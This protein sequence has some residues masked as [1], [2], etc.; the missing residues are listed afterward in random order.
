MD[1]KEQLRSMLAAG[2]SVRRIRE[3]THIHPKTI[4]KL[5]R[6]WLAI[7]SDPPV[8]TGAFPPADTPIP[9]AEPVLATQSDSQVSTEVSVDPLRAP[10]QSG[11][12]MGLVDVIAALLE[13]ASDASARWVWQKLVENH[14]YAGSERS[15]SRYLQ[16]LHRTSPTFFLRLSTLPGQEAQVDY[17]VGPMVFYGGKPRR[18]WFFKMT[19]SHSRHSYEELVFRQDLETF[20]RCHEN[21]F[22]AFG[23][24]PA[25]V[26]IDNLKSG[27]LQAHLYEP[28]LN[29]GYQAFATHAGFVINPCDA[30]QPQ[31]KGKVERD[32]SFTRH[33]AFPGVQVLSS[34]ED[35]NRLLEE[36]NRRW[37]RTRIHGTTRRQV[38]EHF[39]SEEKPALKALPEHPFSM[40]RQGLR[41]VD[42]HGHIQVE[43]VFYSVPAKHLRQQVVARWDSR[44]VKILVADTVVAEHRRE[45]GKSRVVT[46]PGHLPQGMPQNASSFVQYYLRRS[47][48]IGPSC[49]A[50]VQHLLT[51]LNAGNPLAVKRVRGIV[52][53]LSRR[54]GAHILEQACQKAGAFRNPTWSTL[55]TICQKL[56]E[57][58]EA[59][60]DPDGHGH[61]TDLQQ[62][63]RLI[64]DPGDYADVVRDR[65]QEVTR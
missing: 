37:A 56:S 38:W 49:N 29:A 63:H 3:A 45:H 35:G 16:K 23:G 47:Q 9:F 8:S 6:H 2:W 28:R 39:Q 48:E 46:Q 52:V 19:L 14:D 17:A 55:Q 64:R 32:V 13:I 10:T 11:Q 58:I 54:F 57:E 27:V 5:R 43:G 33:N 26:K 15:V 60:P 62:E 42:V 50:L 36:W 65:V 18:S 30:Y 25:E 24:V 4:A 7:Q 1:K 40:L 59:P 22:Q 51:G 20:I 44:V 61:R 31:Q 21:A 53:D 12:L 34:L 41:R